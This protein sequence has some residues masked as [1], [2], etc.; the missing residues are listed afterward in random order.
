MVTN[1][2]SISA[3]ILTGGFLPEEQGNSVRLEA[4][5]LMQIPIYIFKLCLM[6]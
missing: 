2:H 3:Q 4:M 6:N 5:D 1:I